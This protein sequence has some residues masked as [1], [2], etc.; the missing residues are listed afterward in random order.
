M[1]SAKFH[2]GKHLVRNHTRGL[3]RSLTLE[4]ANSLME[5][6]VRNAGV[7]AHEQY[8]WYRENQR[9]LIKRFHMFDPNAKEHIAAHGLV[10]DQ[11]SYNWRNAELNMEVVDSYMDEI[12]IEALDHGNRSISEAISWLQANG[13]ARLELSSVPDR[14]Y[15][16]EYFRAWGAVQKGLSLQL[17]KARTNQKARQTPGFEEIW[18]AIRSIPAGT[19]IGNWTQH[20]GRT[21]EPFIVSSASGDAVAFDVPSAKHEQ[22]ARKYEFE[23]V[24][25]LWDDYRTGKVARSEIVRLTFHSKYII[26]VLKHLEEEGVLGIR[27]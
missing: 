23:L 11:L 3:D 5:E 7:S 18:E 14:A 16:P 27:A 8:H 9:R 12:R 21:G 13:K 10:L 20:K 15:W 1:T 4:V 17:M 26:S 19:R 2:W 24:W 6:I 22:I 25:A